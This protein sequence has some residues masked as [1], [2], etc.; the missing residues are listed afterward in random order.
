MDAK[1]IFDQMT[2][3][4]PGKQTDDVKKEYGLETIVKLASNENPF[5]YSDKV[6][7]AIPTLATHVEIYPD[8][9]ATELREALAG[10]LN[11]KKDQLVFGCGSDEVVDI[12]C[13]TYLDTGMN[14]IVAKPTFPQYKHNALIQGAEVKEIPLHDGYHDL[15]GMLQAIDDNTK[16]VWLCTPNNPTGC[17]IDEAALTAFM[18]KCPSDVLVVVDEAYYEYVT[19]ENMPD[20]IQALKQY[21]NL[22]VLRTFSKAYGLAGLRIGYGI[23]SEKIANL[24]NITRGPFNTTRVAQGAAKIALEDEDFLNSSL[25]KNTKNKQQF[26]QFLDELGLDYYDSETNFVFVKL[27]VSGDALFEHLLSK[28]YIIRSG[29]ALGHPNGVRITIG[30]KA[31]MDAIQ[32][33][34]RSFLAPVIEE[35]RL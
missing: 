8:G 19:S 30:K 34:I 28:G 25:E 14:T 31:D 33:H 26:L 12:I 20:A 1:K 23:T 29:E 27:P 10:K 7:N 15:E 6:A 18:K 24:L 21:S 11:V 32:D 13:R 4:K 3:Y 5:G 35:S 17:L 2:P 22:I 16:I 9:Y